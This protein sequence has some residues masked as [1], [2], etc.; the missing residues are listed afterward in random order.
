MASSSSESLQCRS[1]GNN[2]VRRQ[3]KCYRND[4][5]SYLPQENEAHR[6]PIPL[7]HRKVWGEGFSTG[8]HQ[9]RE[10]SCRYFDELTRSITIST[11]YGH[12]LCQ[13]H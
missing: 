11:A 6:C 8:I 2:L 13:I 10:P 3:P 5:E 7:D 1:N 4:E 12:L 9:H